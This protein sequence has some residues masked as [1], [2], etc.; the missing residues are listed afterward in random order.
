MA[1]T[2][3]SLINLLRWSKVVWP[4]RSIRMYPPQ[5]VI[6]DPIIQ[7]VQKSFTQGH[8]VAVIVFNISNMKDIYEQLSE[9]QYIDF[10]TSIALI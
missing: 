6:R 10:I 3:K 4:L 8:E 5:F 7:A 9:M 1:W 2:T